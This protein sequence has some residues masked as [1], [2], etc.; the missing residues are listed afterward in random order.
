MREVHQHHAFNFLD[1]FWWLW[2]LRYRIMF[3][4]VEK[5]YCFYNLSLCTLVKSLAPSTTMLQ[6]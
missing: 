4:T 1:P 5:Q 3:K 2:F 6:Q